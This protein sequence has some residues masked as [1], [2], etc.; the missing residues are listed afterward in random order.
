MYA[1]VTPSYRVKMKLTLTYTIPIIIMSLIILLLTS[2]IIMSVALKAY[3]ATEN[4]TATPIKHLVVIFQE[5]ISFDHYFATYPYAKN[6][7]DDEHVFHASPNTPTVNNLNSS[8]L[9]TT[10]TNEYQPFRFDRSQAITRDMN[11][12]YTAE[13]NATNGG[14]MDKF[15]KYTSPKNCSDSDCFKQVM[16]YYDGN[17]VTA[18]WNYAQHFAMSDNFFSTTFGPSLLGH[19]NLI[20]GQTH[21]ATIVN[22]KVHETN[23]ND[24]SRIINGTVIGN[25]DPALDDCSDSTHSVILMK[26]RN[27]GD[28]LN[29]K[30]I[31]WGWFSEGFIPSVKTDDGKWHCSSSSGGVLLPLNNT[32]KNHDYYP[33]VEPFQYYNST[34]NIHHLSPKSVATIG[35]TDQANHQ[36]NLSMFWEAADNANLPSASFIKSATSEQ[37][38]PAISDP[39]REQT[40]L[41]NTLNHL[42][43]IPQ[44]NSTAVIIT[45][46][47]SDG[48]YDHVMPPIVSQSNDP[49][50]DGLV[51]PNGL[52][53]H[54][55]AGAYQDRCGYGPRLPLLVISHYAKVNYVDHGITDQSSVLRFIEDNWNLGRIGNQ[56]FDAKAGSILNMFEFGTTDHHAPGLVLDNLTGL[57][58]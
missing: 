28:L 6:P 25:K 33:L 27:I 53:G 52:C 51:G 8:G 56:S 10:N 58:K 16:G 43:E 4:L 45:Y 24:G 19:L 34:A 48:W 49:K 23:T 54:A 17:T 13:Q 7:Q 40:F 46:D 15:V 11:H 36:Y 14:L 47:D 32:N 41:V 50:H 26:G 38:H 37:G 20:S 57:P 18:L 31:T 30:N 39:L 44:W 3:S 35:Q 55:P 29:S 2:P 42:Q 21:N 12:D 5:N 1:E 9:L 22:P